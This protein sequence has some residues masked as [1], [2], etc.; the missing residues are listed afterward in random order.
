MTDATIRL[1]VRVDLAYGDT[2][3]QLKNSIEEFIKNGYIVFNK[4]H[5]QP[6]IKISDA[7]KVEKEE[8][9]SEE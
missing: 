7:D 4:G 6:M 8:Q 2:K 9:E 1:T 3:E 5:I